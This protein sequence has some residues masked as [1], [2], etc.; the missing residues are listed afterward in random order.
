METTMTS[1]INPYAVPGNPV[2]PFNEFAIAR[3]GQGSL[4]RSVI[5]L[6]KI[7]ASQINGCAVCL[8]MHTRDARKAGETEARIY[9]LEAWRDSPLYSERER[10]AIAWTE[11]LTRMDH[12]AMDEA[13]EM[14]A[15]VFKPEEQ[16][17]LNLAIG[18]INVYNRLNA[19]FALKH[20]AAAE[21]RRAA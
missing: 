16:V 9:V 15:A 19:G 5:D 14:V 17:H 7:R 1:H 11:A 2:G 8:N 21:D 12:R 20:P 6:V 4:E 10:A 13:Y 3:E 18:I